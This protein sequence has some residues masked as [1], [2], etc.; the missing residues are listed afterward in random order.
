MAYNEYLDP[1]PPQDIWNVFAAADLSSH[2]SYDLDRYKP[3]WLK[4]K[5]IRYYISSVGECPDACSRALYIATNQEK[6]HPYGG[7]R[8]HFPKNKGQYNYPT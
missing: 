6:L 1:P 2:S 3:A 7:D 4:T 5:V 8:R